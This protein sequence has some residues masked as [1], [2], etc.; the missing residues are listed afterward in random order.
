MKGVGEK[1]VEEVRCGFENPP[2][3]GQGLY[4]IPG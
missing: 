4:D 3:I 2:C 1:I